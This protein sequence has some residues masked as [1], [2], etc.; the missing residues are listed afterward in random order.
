MFPK[1]TDTKTHQ[2]ITLD[3]ALSG[4]KEGRKLKPIIEKIRASETKE[5]RDELKKTLPLVTFGGV[6]TERRASALKEYS[7][8][9]CLDFD[10]VDNIEDFKIE[11]KSDANVMAFFLSPAGNGLKCLI[12]VASDNH[13]G[14]A[15]ALLKEYP[16]ADA[17]AIKEVNRA[18]FLSY[19]PDLYYNPKAEVYTK[20]VENVHSDQ[21]K[22]EK[23]LKWLDG[24]GEK[25]VSG[26]RNSF[27]AK[28]VGA[29]SRFGITEQFSK[30]VVERDFVK[31]SGF[32]QH[33]AFGVIRSIYTNYADQFG[34]ASFDDAF[35]DAEVTNILS[36]EVKASDII[37]LGDVEAD[38]YE[39]YDVGMEGG[40]TTY[41]PELDKHFRWMRGELTALTGI[42]NSGKSTML[43]QLLLFKAVF[44]KQ[45]FGLLS[46]EQYPPV[47][48]YRELIRTLIG[49]PLERDNKARMSRAEY[50][51]AMEFIRNHF[52]FVYPEKDDAT[53]EWTL[54][55]FS[56]VA[57]K[58]GVDGVVIDPHNSQAHDYKSQGGRDD[59]YLASMLSKFQ[60]FALQNQNYF[61]DVAH[62]RG[63]GK[64]PDGSYKEPTADEISGGPVWWQRC[65]NILIFHRPKL[66]LDFQDPA[67]TLRSAKIKKQQLNGRP[68]VADFTY[69]WK[70]GRYYS[71]GFNPLDKFKL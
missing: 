40:S 53:P 31:N 47:F 56:E 4:I 9:I 51:R 24:K 30:E 69:D 54:A 23:L 12:K 46:M 55:R 6:F 2:H 32:P 14:H 33:E 28:L 20:I 15:L 29:M 37:T 50:E 52:F 44:E 68:G 41:F 48:F 57:I 70:I 19:D 17:N 45:K 3:T 65:D 25:F 61:I 60:R 62:P 27:L 34:T 43:A 66:P 7:R 5:E 22:Y 39:D 58:F 36:S 21:Q 64:N 10:D 59:R 13:L 42:A 16:N 49:K 63:I 67:C 11:L 35:S 38:L 26:N 71:N 8:L 1:L 18:C